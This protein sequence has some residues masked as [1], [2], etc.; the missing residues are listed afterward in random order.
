M[1]LQV[2]VLKAE[3]HL[4]AA[5]HNALPDSAAQMLQ[6]Q[7]SREPGKFRLM[8]HR[9]ALESLILMD[10]PANEDIEPHEALPAR[11]VSSFS[12]FFERREEEVILN[13]GRLHAAKE[14]EADEKAKL[15]SISHTS[16]AHVRVLATLQGRCELE[17]FAPD[18]LCA[19][20]S[21]GTCNPCNSQQL[22]HHLVG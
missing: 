18:S 8:L 15:V 11:R 22:L 1:H 21:D 9:H 14:R 4:R 16:G 10:Q 2:Q 3:N 7:M 13:K 6:G 5:H 19:I 17:G 20:Q 12:R